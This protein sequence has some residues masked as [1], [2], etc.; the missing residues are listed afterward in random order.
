MPTV[1][2]KGQVTLPKPIRDALGLSPGSRVE[3]VVE[4]GRVILRRQVPQE[5]F[6]QWRGYLRGKLPAQSVDEMME[7]LRG[8]RLSDE[9]Q[10]V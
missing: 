1:T 4:N 2:R 7:L 9:G 5:V 8:E 6:A 3:F 10:G